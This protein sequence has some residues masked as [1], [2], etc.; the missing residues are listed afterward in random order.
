MGA[1]RAVSAAADLV[2]YD[3]LQLCQSNVIAYLAEVYICLSCVVSQVQSG[4]SR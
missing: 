1:T 2:C 4:F 3:L